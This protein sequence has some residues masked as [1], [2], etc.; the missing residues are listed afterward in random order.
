M[1]ETWIWVA[2]SF[3]LAFLSWRFVERPARHSKITAWP[4]FAA[5]ALTSGALIGAGGV[6]F[7]KDGMLE[8]PSDGAFQGL[9]LCPIGPEGTPDILIWGDSHVRA[10]KEGLERQAF[11]SDVP[12]LLIW[13]AGCAPVFGLEKDETSASPAQDQ[14]CRDAN[15]EI[16]TAL[17]TDPFKR[18]LLVG[19]WGYYVRRRAKRAICQR[20]PTHRAIFARCRITGHAPKG[21]SGNCRL[22]FTAHCAFARGQPD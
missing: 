20:S 2:L 10:M 7:I 9:E 15:T 4:T 19:R 12:A 16:E 1:G 14:A 5:A 8:V 17:L 6:I 18:I 22:R 13:R 11:E 21:H 3:A